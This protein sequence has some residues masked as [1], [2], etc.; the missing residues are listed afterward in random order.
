MTRRTA[1]LRLAA[2]LLAIPFVPVA[3]NTAPGG[4]SSREDLSARVQSVISDMKARDPGMDK[5]FST[6]FGYAVMP[7]IAKGAII[8]GGAFGNGEV[9]EKGTMI[10]WCSVT[11]GTV[12]L[13]LGGG[14]TAQAIFFENQSALDAFKQGVVALDAQATGYAVT[15]GGSEKA[16]FDHGMAVFMFDPRGLMGDASVGGQG[17]RFVPLSDAK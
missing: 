9:F 8:F 1:P 7:D 12:G 11:S 6:S 16:R 15:A 5:W 14:V 13:S 17:F 4:E 10:G 2:A 3:C